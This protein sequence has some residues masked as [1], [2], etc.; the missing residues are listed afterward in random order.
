M[1]DVMENPGKGGQQGGRGLDK[2]HEITNTETGEKRQITQRDWK[3]QGKELR[4]QGW[5]RAEDDQDA[6]DVDPDADTGTGGVEE[7]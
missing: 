1:E 7:V 2:E 5:A 3:D 4:S 6:D